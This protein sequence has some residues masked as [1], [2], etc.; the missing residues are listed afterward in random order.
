[1]KTESKF[2]LNSIRST[3]SNNYASQVNLNTTR[4]ENPSRIEKLH[5]IILQKTKQ[6]ENSSIR[7]SSKETYKSELPSCLFKRK[8]K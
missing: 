8:I 1:L 6:D 5:R 2:V 4:A 3:I 7:P